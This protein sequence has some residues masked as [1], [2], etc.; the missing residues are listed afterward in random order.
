VKTGRNQRR[1]TKKV[2]VIVTGGRGGL[3]V[4]GRE[5]FRTRL[6]CNCERNGDRRN[7]Q[8]GES[9][10]LIQGGLDSVAEG[11]GRD[12]ILKRPAPTQ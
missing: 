11:R 12:E 4:E 7:G 3:H 8:V 6:V 9:H 1:G 5:R 10:G 2:T